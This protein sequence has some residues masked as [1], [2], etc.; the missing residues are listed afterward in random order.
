MKQKEAR[1]I[2]LHQL[3]E[4]IE[5]AERMEKAVAGTDIC[6]PY[7]REYYNDWQNSISLA[8]RII[9]DQKPEKGQSAYIQNK[10]R[11]YINEKFHGKLWEKYANMEVPPRMIEH[12]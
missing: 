12:K 8:Q 6:S 10:W 7:Y 3:E 9:K 11:A 2:L 1:E 5:N 4:S